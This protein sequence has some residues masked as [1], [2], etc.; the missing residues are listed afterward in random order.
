MENPQRILFVR[1]DR[2]GDTLLS[3]P[4]LRALRASYPQA[5]I[6][7][8]TSPTGLPAVENNPD[9][10]DIL[11]YDKRASWLDHWRLLRRLRA[12]RFDAAVIAHCN[13][14]VNWLA[15]LAGIPRRIGH[16]RKA[17]FLLTQPLPN[18]KALGH[19]HEADHV[20]DL[21]K[22]AC[23]EAFVAP[24]T[25]RPVFIV[26]KPEKDFAAL[27][28]KKMGISGHKKLI[29][30]H[31]GSSAP[32]KRWPSRYF[33][34]LIG[35]LALHGDWQVLL[36]GGADEMDLSAGIIPAGTEK[37]IVD[38]TG[39]LNVPEL[40]AMLE[41]CAL[42]ISNDSGPVHLAA[43]VGTPIV[44]I[45]GRNRPGLGPK[46]WGPLGDRD[47]VLQKDV[48]CTECLADDCKIAFKCLTELSVEE[49]YQA[50]LASL[51]GVRH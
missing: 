29:A 36:V 43:A 16:A 27:M 1:T 45:F 37:R 51:R 18:V 19:K 38:F 48:G 23:G 11:V 6:S 13:N 33:S 24:P 12:M 7:V 39:L 20:L 40:A 30:V 34:E 10:Q 9:A 41:R 42:F 28:L 32:S 47:M 4:G 3:T 49:V 2:L 44:A 26:Q 35:K 8:L 31:A 5:W 21:V 50:A 22:E 15:F 14:A 25:R 17:G 46:S